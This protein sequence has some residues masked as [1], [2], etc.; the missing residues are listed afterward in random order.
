MKDE[1]SSARA[2]MVFDAPWFAT[3]ALNLGLGTSDSLQIPRVDGKTFQFPK[4]V[5]ESCSKHELKGML[6]AG[7]LACALGHPFRIGA[8]D[9]DTWSMASSCVTG[10]LARE[11]GFS[12]PEW[13]PEHTDITSNTSIEDAYTILFQEQEQE[14]DGGDGDGNTDGSDGDSNGSGQGMTVAPPRSGGDD[15]DADG[16]GGG[17][18]E[19]EG[20]GEQ[21]APAA[22][23]GEQRKLEQEWN[24]R[25]V[26]AAQAL[27]KS[28]G[29]VPGWMQGIIDELTKP[30]LNWV[31]ILREFLTVINKDD[32]DLRHPDVRLSGEDF[33]FPGLWSEGAP[34]LVIGLDYSGSVSKPE[35]MQFLAELNSMLTEYDVPITVVFFDSI[36]QKVE[37]Y[38]RENLPVRDDCGYGGTR[39]TPLFDWISENCFEAP[40]AVIV[41]SDMECGDFPRYAPDFPVLW[42]ST[43]PWK[44]VTQYFPGGKLPFG[45]PLEVKI[46]RQ[47]YW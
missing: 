42:V 37:E 18:G 15:A 6:A 17:G 26:Q 19:N 38:T 13:W 24:V 29:S 46:N 16:D 32:F 10:R 47:S 36:V 30:Q 2:A 11:S 12:L 41:C 7:S 39:F 14:P 20:E 27:K 40:T 4:H 9:V 5:L 25:M 3:L 31:E 35:R 34:R 44:R 8:R 23:R 45:M 33:V 22:S 21:Q 1:L 28:Q 43:Q